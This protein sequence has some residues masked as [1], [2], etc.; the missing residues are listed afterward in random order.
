[1]PK[2]YQPT[3]T[4]THNMTHTCLRNK[5]RLYTRFQQTSSCSTHVRTPFSESTDNTLET[6]AER[7]KVGGVTGQTDKPQRKG[8]TTEHI[9]SATQTRSPNFTHVCEG[10]GNAWGM[11][12]LKATQFL[13][14]RGKA[15]SRHYNDCIK[16]LIA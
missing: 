2:A 12:R 10:Q 11:R 13:P 6:E 4:W 8:R 5:D 16:R 9:H 7:I 3:L 14:R 15:I 1:M